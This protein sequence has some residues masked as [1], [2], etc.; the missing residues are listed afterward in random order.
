MKRQFHILARILTPTLNELVAFGEQYIV[1]LS[2]CEASIFIL[3]CTVGGF[4]LMYLATSR[5]PR[6]HFALPNFL[7][8]IT[9]T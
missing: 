5:H 9:I 6:A 7:K 8:R 4:T 3:G 2:L 1:L